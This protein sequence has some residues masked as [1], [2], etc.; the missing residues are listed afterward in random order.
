MA[1]AASGAGYAIKLYLHGHGP[2]LI[3]LGVLPA[4]TAIYFGL[5]FAFGI[6]ELNMLV[7]RILPG[8]SA[9]RRSTNSQ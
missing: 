1:L 9:G 3:G 5:A 4:F 7:A 6:P 8:L 2:K